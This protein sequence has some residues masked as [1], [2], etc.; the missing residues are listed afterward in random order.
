MLSDAQLFARFC[1]PLHPMPPLR[2]VDTPARA[3]GLF[4][5]RLAH[6]EVEELHIAHLSQGCTLLAVECLT[7]GNDHCTVVDPRQ[8]Y[9]RA[10]RW[11]AT[12]ILL[13]H[14]HPGGSPDPSP[15]DIRATQRIVAA[16]QGLGI[17]LVDHLIITRHG[18]SSMAEAG[19][20]APETPAVGTLHRC[21]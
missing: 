3:L 9:R 6:L 15:A 10:L 18:G 5:P 13:A 16:G 14:N 7:R 20:M 2:L 12:R 21:T 4:R 17:G 11:G 1:A 19:L 8:I